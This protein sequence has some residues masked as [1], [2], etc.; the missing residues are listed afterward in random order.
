MRYPLL[1][2]AATGLALFSAHAV[3]GYATAY[4][5]GYG[6]LTLMAALIAATFLWLWRKRATPL[7]LGMA[8]GW[9]G[10]ASVLGWWLTYDLMDRPD[11]M[12]ESPELFVFLA[13]YFVG[14]ILHFEVIGR[15]L[16]LRRPLV[17]VP[18]LAAVLL[19]WVLQQVV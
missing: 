3:F 5:V 11:W 6:A 10:A 2:L 9:A 13:M 19:S 18:V 14:A 7:A 8:F 16:G 4:R 1:L 17:A 15:S 12:A